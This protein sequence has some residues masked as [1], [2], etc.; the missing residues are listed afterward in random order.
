MVAGQCLA[1]T[2]VRR[3]TVVTDSDLSLPAS[4]KHGRVCAKTACEVAAGMTEEGDE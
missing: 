1:W 4:P 3:L 2:S